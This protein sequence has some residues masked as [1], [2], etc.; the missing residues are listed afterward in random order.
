MP[1]AK[2][3]ERR[4]TQCDALNLNTS[5]E[6]YNCGYPLT[7]MTGTNSRKT[8]TKKFI[9]IFISLCGLH[10][11]SIII[12]LLGFV[13]Q[14]FNLILVPVLFLT[15]LPALLLE[16]LGFNFTLGEGGMIS[17]PSPDGLLI[18]LAFWLLLYLIIAYLFSRKI[19]A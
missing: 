10:L 13:F 9:I 16:K 1:N 19:P 12:G 2:S 6:C 14:P 7:P 5:R 3:D 17:F 8:K 4:C 18:C 15:T 11:A